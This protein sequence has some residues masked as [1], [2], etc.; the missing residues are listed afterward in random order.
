M[1]KSVLN[2]SIVPIVAVCLAC[3]NPKGT[4]GKAAVL[5]YDCIIEGRYDDYVGGIAYSDSMTTDYR[6]QM[7]DLTAQY[8]RR[9]VESRGGL[10]EVR[11]LDDIVSG[12]VATVFMELVYEDS[13]SEEVCVPMVLCGDEWKMQ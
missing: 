6:S 2:L 12:N 13:T 11:L 1:M 3:G 7:A 4:P 5:Y 9:E 10:K 8:A